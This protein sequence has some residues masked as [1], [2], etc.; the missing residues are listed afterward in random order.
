M[1]GCF[2]M[3]R[4]SRQEGFSVVEALVVVVA[5]VAIGL[6]GVLVYQHNRTKTTGATGGT[7]TTNQQT[8]TTTPAPTVSYLAVKEWGVQLPLSSAINDAYY[9]VPS[10]ISS[11]PDGKPS[12]IY[13]GVTSLN[14]SCG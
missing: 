12:G 1:Q 6:A 14:T 10:G 2:D 3:G 4:Q 13:L 11:D 8:T 7:Q 9:T 5:V